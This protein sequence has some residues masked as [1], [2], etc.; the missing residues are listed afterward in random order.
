MESDITE[1]EAPPVA[2]CAMICPLETL[3]IFRTAPRQ[4]ST[5][6]GNN[7]ENHFY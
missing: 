4:N 3:C 1:R 2:G 6:S 5:K 7:R